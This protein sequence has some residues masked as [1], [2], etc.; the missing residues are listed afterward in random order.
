M[1]KREVLILL[2]PIPITQERPYNSASFWKITAVNISI[3]SIKYYDG[4]V[5]YQQRTG[6]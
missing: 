3:F 4:S 5:Y 1:E 2:I 6:I